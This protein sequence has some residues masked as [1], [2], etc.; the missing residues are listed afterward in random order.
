MKRRSLLNFT[1]RV[2]QKK[3]QLHTGT[4]KQILILAE[5][6][7]NSLDGFLNHRTNLEHKNNKK[8]NQHGH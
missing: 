7:Q 6:A 3:E 4:S 8:S 2:Q 5:A 1:K